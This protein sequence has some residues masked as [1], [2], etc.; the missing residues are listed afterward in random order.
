MNDDLGIGLTA[1]LCAIPAERFAKLAEV[2]DDAVVDHCD[3]LSR[4]RMRVQLGWFAVGRPA[5]MT[6]A[7]CA[8]DR[9]ESEPLLEVL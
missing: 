5:G 4:M 2:F 9:F 3:A 6:D 7:G 1:E 8:L